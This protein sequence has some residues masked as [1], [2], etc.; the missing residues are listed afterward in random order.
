MKTL[1]AAPDFVTIVRTSGHGRALFAAIH[2]FGA[3]PK[4]WM[5]GIKPAT[6]DRSLL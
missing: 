3:P 2:V 1:G 5:A 6:G 4:T